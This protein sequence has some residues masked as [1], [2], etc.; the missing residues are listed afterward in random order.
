MAAASVGICGLALWRGH[1]ARRCR[2]SSVV[3]ASGRRCSILRVHLSSPLCQSVRAYSERQRQA[4]VLAEGGG[5]PTLSRLVVPITEL[6]TSLEIVYAAWHVRRLCGDVMYVCHS[7]HWTDR[8]NAERTAVDIKAQ[9]P[10]I[11]FVVDLLCSL[12]YSK[13]TTNCISGDWA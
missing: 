11:R 5:E 8:D 10:L 9:T 3:H 12:L 6:R 13:S 4:G 1:P 2:Q 7:I